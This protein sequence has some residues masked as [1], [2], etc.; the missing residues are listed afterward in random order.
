LS[1]RE[2]FGETWDAVVIGAGVNG[3]VAANALA[4]KGWQ[5]LVLE[6]QPEVGGAVRSG[7]IADAFTSDLYSAF[8]PLAAAS[9]VIRA[10][11]LERYGLVWVQA[12]TV[13][14]HQLDD[15]GVAVIHRDVERT[16]ASFDEEHPGDGEAW[17][18]MVD[19]WRR[20][21]EPILRALF[22]PFPPL[23]A[24]VA[25][26]RALKI[27]G[28]LR[29]ARM[30]TLPVRRLAEESFGGTSPR[31]LLTGNA[32]HADVPPVGAGSGVFGWLLTMLAQDVGFPVPQG[33]SC[34]LPQALSARGAA[35][36]VSIRLRAP[37]S[38]VL[39][40]SGRAT[41][42]R[43]ADGTR[44]G[45][46]RAVIADVSAPHLYE[47][48]LSGADLP[49][50][51]RRDLRRFQWDHSTLK[52]NWALSGPVPWLGRETGFAGTVHLG[53]DL[54][55]FVEFSSDLELGRMPTNPFVLFGQM[56]TADPSR[57]PFGTE[58]AWAYTHLPRR[59][60]GD[61][62]T[63]RAHAE[64]VQQV[65]ERVA[66]GFGDLVIASSLQT[67]GDL[68]IG[69]GNLSGGAVNAGTSALHQQLFF[70][71]T[72]GTGRPDTVVDGL[73]LASASAH[74]GGGVHG[75]CGWNAA[76]AALV[77]AGAMGGLRRRIGRRVSHQIWEH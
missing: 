66:P 71:P 5:V 75:A 48:L 26:L 74:P 67:P 65:V 23:G 14:A 33:G 32:M 27:A 4:D 3:L 22:T 19:E 40:H 39:V 16:A 15:G 30:I 53:V 54:D 68:E 45:A 6:A 59:L 64:L 73:F 47:Q 70:R 63:V 11:E 38:E 77:A 57:S 8:Y 28:A 55:G 56:S 76:R 58:S 69:D 49:A 10:M 34:R 44:L 12:P 62:T 60:A 61:D 1:G 50:Q 25:L 31:L 24:G 7:S 9:P 13:L 37:V 2:S 42:V 35:R 18:A 17:L 51:L 52:L 43:L 46:R 20:L 21:R 29:L 36:G 41:G 72:P